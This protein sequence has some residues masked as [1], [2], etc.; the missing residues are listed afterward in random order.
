MVCLVANVLHALLAFRTGPPTID[1]VAAG[2]CATCLKGEWQATVSV[3]LAEGHYAYVDQ[4]VCRASVAVGSELLKI[5]R[6]ATGS[7]TKAAHLDVVSS[8]VD[9]VVHGNWLGRHL[10]PFGRATAECAYLLVALPQDR[11]SVV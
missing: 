4:P 8:I 11:K 9:N 7:F 10:N 1:Y 5:A 3:R 6:I 2:E